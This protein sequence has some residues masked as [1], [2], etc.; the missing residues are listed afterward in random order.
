LQ[1]QTLLLNIF[2]SLRENNLPIKK[3]ANEQH[4]TRSKKFSEKN[5][6]VNFY[7]IILADA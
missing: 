1:R 3:F 7:G 6:I 4:G 5:C 2:A